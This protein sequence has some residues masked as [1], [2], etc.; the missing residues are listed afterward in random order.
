MNVIWCD[1][2]AFDRLP[3]KPWGRS[4]MREIIRS[5]AARRGISVEEIK[6][7]HLRKDIVRARHEAMYLCRAEGCWS[8]PQI[9]A[10]F[11]GR[12]HTSVMNGVRRHAERL[13][14]DLSA[15]RR[16]RGLAAVQR[17]ASG[18]TQ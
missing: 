2:E 14:E 6:G 1:P 13:E 12:D 9:G 15:W 10:A 18:G 5:V 7:P 3:V 11:G 4:T 17:L 8:F 16:L